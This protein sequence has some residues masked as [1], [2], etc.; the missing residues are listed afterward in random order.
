MAIKEVEYIL[1]VEGL[2][3]FEKT[4]QNFEF[5]SSYLKVVALGMMDFENWFLL[6]DDL[7]KNRHNS[8]KQR[9]KNRN[10][11][12]F[13]KRG[14]CDDVACFE[15]GQGERVFIVHDYADEGWERRQEFDDFWAWFISAIKELIEIE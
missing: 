3:E 7:V 12:P 14:D 9:Y 1:T 15:I 2:K 8:M 11:V 10:L 6:S 5:P 4:L 13:A